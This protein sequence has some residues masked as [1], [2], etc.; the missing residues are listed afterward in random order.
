MSFTSRY[1]RYLLPVITFILVV[2]LWAGIVTAFNVPAYVFPSPAELVDAFQRK[3]DVLWEAFLITLAT[4]AGG[5]ALAASLGLVLA[6]IFVRFNWVEQ[7]FMPYVILTQ[8]TPVVAVA[9]LIVLWAGN[10]LWSRTIIATLICFFPIVVNAVKGLGSAEPGQ[11]ELLHTYSA[12]SNQIFRLL[13]LP[14]ALPDIFAALRI[15]ATLCVIGSV[16]GELV[17][18]NSGLGFII[19]Q[20]S[21]QL[22]TPLLFAA[23]ICAALLGISLFVSMILLERPFPQCRHRTA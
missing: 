23:V 17:T 15:S 2:C 22:D 19:L 13:R 14:A 7:A 8:T 1:R 9:P 16:V 11:L 18:G 3:G 10:G 6:T 5:L 4:S 20:A 21:Y 12:G